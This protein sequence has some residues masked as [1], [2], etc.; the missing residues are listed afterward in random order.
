M[1]DIIVIGAGPAGLTA[2]IYGRRA[3]KKVL[4]LEAS[5]YGG[6]IIN[7]LDIENYPGE[8]HISGYDL[9]QK[10]YDQAKSLGAEIKYEKVIDL[11]DYKESKEVITSNNTYSTKT[12]II[13][14]G[15]KTK[16]LGIDNEENLIGKGISYCATCDGAFYKNR[17][18]AVIGG[19][20]RAVEDAIYL[21]D[22]ANKVY[23]ICRKDK[24]SAPELYIDKLFKKNNI[25]I[26]YES[27]ISSINGE[28]VLSSIDIVNNNDEKRN[29]KIS[30]LF[31]AIGRIPE[32]NNFIKYVDI[33]KNGYIIANENC[34]TKTPGIF[35]AGDTREKELR[36]LVTAT[37]DGAIAASEAIKYINGK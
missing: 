15:S 11:N 16:S 33:N 27:N 20:S 19:G 3:N 26:V 25:E 6:Q 9:A 24:L 1:Y 21:S 31:I 29:I 34:Q 13:A 14:T 7:T 10:I 4:V 17:D 5:N 28:E 37:S 23:L 32:N 22:I 12:V 30:G 36:Q 2:A 18:V 35:V 8:N